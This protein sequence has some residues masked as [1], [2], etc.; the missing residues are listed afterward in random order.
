MG[1]NTLVLLIT[2]QVALKFGF[3]SGDSGSCLSDW[4]AVFGQAYDY[5]SDKDLRSLNL[6]LARHESCIRNEVRQRCPKSFF[7]PEGRDL[8]HLDCLLDETFIRLFSFSRR[9]DCSDAICSDPD[10][11]DWGTSKAKKLRGDVLIW[12]EIVPLE[13]ERQIVNEDRSEI[14]SILLNNVYSL[15]QQNDFGGLNDFLKGMRLPNLKQLNGIKL[16]CTSDSY[17]WEGDLACSWEKLLKELV[18]LISVHESGHAEVKHLTSTFDYSKKLEQLNAKNI[19]ETAAMGTQ[20]S[21]KEFATELTLVINDRFDQLGDYFTTLADYDGEIAKGDIDD[22][23]GE[24]EGFRN[25]QNKLTAE[26]TELS[27]KLI[28]QTQAVAAA[29]AVIAW[30]KVY[31]TT[32]LAAVSA[33]SG[34]ASGFIDAWDKTDEAVEAALNAVRSETLSTLMTELTGEM[35]TIKDNLDAGKDLLDQARLIV[36]SES[37]DEPADL[38]AMKQVQWEF[39]QAYN[40][41]SSG[42]SNANIQ[43]VDQGMSNVLDV[44]SEVL[45]ESTQ[46]I[47]S[48][49]GKGEIIKSNGLEDMALLIPQITAL[50]ESRLE[51]QDDYIN[52][53]AAYLRSKMAGAS[54]QELKNSIEESRER[55]SSTRNNVAKNQAALT[56]LITSKAH[57]L[58]AVRHACHVLEYRNAGT[59]PAVCERALKSLAVEDI[60]D[61]IAFVPESCVENTDDGAYVSIPVTKKYQSGAISLQDLYLKKRA[62]FQIPDAQWLVDHGWLLRSDAEEKVFYVKGFELFL[63]SLEKTSGGRHVGVDISARSSA[64]LVKT[65]NSGSSQKYDIKPRQKFEF[66]YKENIPPCDKKEANPYELCPDKPLSDICVVKD[67]VIN[68]DL[69]L[70]PSIFSEWVIEVPDL[71]S[72]TEL[73]D[74]LS[75]E[76]GVFSLQAK[77]MMC[78][79]VPDKKAGARLNEMPRADSSDRREACGVGNYYDRKAFQWRECPPGSSATLAGYYCK[80]GTD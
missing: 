47:A 21:L 73:P 3:T 1:S 8:S 67:G 11:V 48:V 64:P 63:L 77:I 70:Y 13:T 34:D 2:M 49:A 42:V 23:V 17:N 75:E 27:T 71:R 40:S 69:D 14:I 78:S 12:F 62:T 58:Q 32:A 36:Q 43:K 6:L 28:D 76:D 44:I 35:E 80:P 57:S 20:N 56:A 18:L 7:S 30:V 54:V 45:S 24:L 51:Y 19:V 25:Q 37:E 5:V 50:L 79:K 46:A 66:S 16:D 31:A 61:V 10:S 59:M 38:D 26:F 41:F 29:N 39:L 72:H 33:A 4:K 60:M 65:T 55:G 74:F 52:S 68:N 15:L 9:L 22:I 53:L